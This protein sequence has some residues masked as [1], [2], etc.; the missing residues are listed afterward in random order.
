[1][2]ANETIVVD[3]SSPSEMNVIKGVGFRKRHQTAGLDG[4]YPSFF[5]DDGEVLTFQLTELRGSLWQGEEVATNQ[6][7]SVIVPILVRV[8]SELV[9]GIILYRLSE[10]GERCVYENQRG[11]RPG[12][13]RVG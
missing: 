4:K 5:K 10:S 2:A 9:Q 13:D 7:E 3:T 8:A 12:C 6:C 1:M 11:F